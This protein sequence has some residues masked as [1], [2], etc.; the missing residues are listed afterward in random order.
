MRAEGQ[1]TSEGAA[2]A[3]CISNNLRKHECSQ[4]KANQIRELDKRLGA[5]CGLV[6]SIWRAEV[7]ISLAN[8]LLVEDGR[9]LPTRM[10]KFGAQYDRLFPWRE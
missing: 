8:P 3:F 10:P 5:I 4:A 1:K 2:S 9:F 7:L 6:L